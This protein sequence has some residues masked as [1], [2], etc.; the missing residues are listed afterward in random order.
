MTSLSSIRTRFVALLALLALA[1][2]GSPVVYAACSQYWTRYCKGCVTIYTVQST[3]CRE[4]GDMWCCLKTIHK[5]CDDDGDPDCTDL[6]IWYAG[7]GDC[8]PNPCD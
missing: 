7:T 1:G 4:G 8:S 3:S 2:F 5:D 6:G